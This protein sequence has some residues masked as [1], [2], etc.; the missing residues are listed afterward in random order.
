M[1]K[2]KGGA[3]SKGLFFLSSPALAAEAAAMPMLLGVR[4]DQLSPTGCWK[5]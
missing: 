4:F 2:A 3:M 5:R 1:R